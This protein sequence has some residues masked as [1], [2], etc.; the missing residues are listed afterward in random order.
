MAIHTPTYMHTP[1]LWDTRSARTTLQLILQA[2]P[3]LTNSRGDTSKRL[4]SR[5]ATTMPLIIDL[6]QGKQQAAKYAGEYGSGA[7]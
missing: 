7:A 5:P 1:T 4:L 3:T 6:L 2:F